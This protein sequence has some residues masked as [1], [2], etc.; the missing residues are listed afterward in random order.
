MHSIASPN[1]I[2]HGD[3]DKFQEKS[4]MFG[5]LIFFSFRPF[6]DYHCS[7]PGAHDALGDNF[8]PQGSM[9][10]LVPNFH[11]DSANGTFL[12]FGSME[13]LNEVCV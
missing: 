8:T 5:V 6:K 13:R 9:K 2:P 11:P 12:L 1:N 7:G 10:M 4:V 3:D